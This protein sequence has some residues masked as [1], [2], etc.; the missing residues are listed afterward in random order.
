MSTSEKI[1]NEL[2]DLL[3][4]VPSLL[5][6]LKKEENFIEFGTT[7][8][9]WYSRAYK[10][11]ELLGQERL[12]EFTSYYRIDCKRKMLDV[13]NYVIQD[14]LNN[15][16][17]FSLGDTSGLARGKIINQLQIL[18]SL[19]SRIDSILQDVKGH[20]LADIQDSELKVADQLRKVSLR[21]AGALAE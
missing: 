15:I 5:D 16:T 10:V 4:E 11:V 2:E 3:R 19:E 1:K 21:A 9:V 20:L 18:M 8:Q 6:L 17:S 14:Y 12:E 7:Y 13:G